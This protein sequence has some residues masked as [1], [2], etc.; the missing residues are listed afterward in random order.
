[1]ATLTQCYL[2]LRARRARLREAETNGWRDCLPSER[3]NVSE[4]E[5]AFVQLLLDAGISERLMQLA[6]GVELGTLPLGVS[7]AF[8]RNRVE[9]PVV[10]AL[11]DVCESEGGHL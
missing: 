1:M 5:H 7:L 2:E 10:E 6:G 3:E 8:S 11:D 4:F 9:Q